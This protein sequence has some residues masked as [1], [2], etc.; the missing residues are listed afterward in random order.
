VPDLADFVR[1]A[2][3]AGKSREEVTEVLD[4]AGWAQDEIADALGQFADV[5]FPIPVPLRRTSGS[6]REAFLYLVTYAALYTAAIAL[7]NL[8]CGFVDQA[9]PET[10]RNGYD[11]SVYDNDSMRWLVASLVISFP[12]WLLLTRAHLI[13]YSRDPERR[14]SSV[15]SWLT[16]LT[17]TTAAI[18]MMVTG[19]DLLATF[20]GGE[21]ILRTLLKC[22][23]VLLIAGSILWFYLWDLRCTERRVT[24]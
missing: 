1:E 13:S 17:L 15:R 6:A 4:Q 14:R 24:A 23:I 7:G 9:L 11:T 3:R 22:L 5:P 12:I 20:L 8:L 18:T 21:Q 10:V 19:I 16:Y 2:L